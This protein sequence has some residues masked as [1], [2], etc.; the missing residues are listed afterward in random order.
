MVLFCQMDVTGRT[1]EDPAATRLV[2]NIL[3]YVSNTSYPV[4]P[5][6][7]ALYVGDAVG[8]RYL[9]HAGIS[10]GP[11][12]GGELSTDAVLIVA[13]VGGAQPQGVVFLIGMPVLDETL[14]GGFYFAILIQG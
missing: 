14:D 2:R 4:R 10:S 8:R 12:R 3:S 1:E 6:R 5:T 11:Y 7:K 13:E 9:E